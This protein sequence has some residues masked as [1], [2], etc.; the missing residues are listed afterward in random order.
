MVSSVDTV[1]QKADQNRGRFVAAF[2]PISLSKFGQESNLQL[3]VNLDNPVAVESMCKAR[4]GIQAVF[5]SPKSCK[6]PHLDLGKIKYAI[7]SSYTEF[8]L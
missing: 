6:Y 4:E 5:S 3:V 7:M 2:N 8:C 1:F